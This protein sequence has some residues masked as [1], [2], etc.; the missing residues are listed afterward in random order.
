MLDQS[1]VTAAFDRAEHYSGY[2]DIQ[3][4]IAGELA[5]RIAQLNLPDAARVLEIGCGTG[6]L[7]RELLDRKIGHDWLITDKAPAMVERCRSAVGEEPGREFAVLDGEYGLGMIEGRFDIICASMAMQWFDDL[8]NAV[9]RL[10]ARL[11]SGG[12]LVFNTLASGTFS[13]WRDAHEQCGLEAGAIV[14][15]EANALIALL[16]SFSPE[17]LT[18]ER[19]VEHHDNARKFLDRLKCIGAATPRPSHVPLAPG[20]LK[21]V[22]AA[23][24]RAGAQTTYE[25]VT[26]H[27]AG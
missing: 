3:R 12:H 21:R 17:I 25:V 15:P 6:F 16:R 18:V 8:S 4:L 2:A 13:E 5:S 24:D 7:T 26:C 20:D 10:I 11:G 23:F 27:I 9:Q 22:M 19:H 14:F 1:R